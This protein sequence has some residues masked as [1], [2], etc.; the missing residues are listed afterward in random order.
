MGNGKREDV[1]G[2]EYLAAWLQ[3]GIEPEYNKPDS[4]TKDLRVQDGKN[5]LRHFAEDTYK[6]T[7]RTISQ[8]WELFDR[9]LFGDRRGESPLRYGRDVFHAYNGRFFAPV[10]D[11]GFI[12]ELVRRTLEKLGVNSAY[13][14]YGAND[15]A[16]PLINRLRTSPECV[17]NPSRRWIC[18]NNGVLDVEGNRFIHEFG[19]KYCTD[20]VLDIDYNPNPGLAERNFWRDK[21]N[22]IIPSAG[23]QG[24]FQQFC[25]SII[26][27]RELYRNEYICYIHGNGGNGKSVLVNA[28]AGVFGERYYS[29]FT[30]EQIF[31]KET[32]SLFVAKELDGKLLN[33]CDDTADRDLGM[34]SLKNFISGGKIQSRGVGKGKFFKVTPPL[35]LS[36][37]NVFPDIADDSDGYHRRQLIIETTMRKFEGEDRDT[38][39]QAKFATPEMR[40][41]IF[42]WIYE[43]FRMFK[44]NKGDIKLSE[45]AVETRDFRRQTSSPMRY[46]AKERGFTALAP[47]EDLKDPLWRSLHDIY[48]DYRTF[49]AQSGCKCE[50]DKRKVGTMLRS[51]GIQ[52]HNITRLGGTAFRIGIKKTEENN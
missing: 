8:L 26:A 52:S 28:I 45:D 36:C 33:I 30:L 38:Q 41:V 17:Y 20:V 44:R 15:I 13:Q 22:Q 29:T 42:N 48:A 16:K 4:R 51:M 43:G 34:S 6:P 14:C 11:S 9:R 47:T 19:M 32:A 37:I 24:D 7:K 35:L 3:E 25:G 46:W 27:D 50:A 39:L 10:E 40:C 2:L 5:W 12:T 23:F 1:D 21:L 49:C 18:F 31:A